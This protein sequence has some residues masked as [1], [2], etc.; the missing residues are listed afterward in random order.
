MTTTTATTT[1]AATATAGTGPTAAAPTAAAPT[2][3]N[4]GRLGPGE[5]R[6]LVASFLDAGAGM[7]FTPGEIA[8]ILSRSS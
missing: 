3:P 5:L 4:S 8:R 6:R 2:G 7:A 1:A